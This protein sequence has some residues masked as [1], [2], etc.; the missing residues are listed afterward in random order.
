MSR[1]EVSIHFYDA[2]GK[3]ISPNMR[4]YADI[5]RIGA[6]ETWHF[7][8]KTENLPKEPVTMEVIAYE[9]W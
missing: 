2:N 4:S 5:Q 3:E 8:V 6:G 7:Y 1:S 9:D